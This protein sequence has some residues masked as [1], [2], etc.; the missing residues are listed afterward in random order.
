MKQAQTIRQPN[1][2]CRWRIWRAYRLGA[3]KLATQEV[4]EHV[5]DGEFLWIARDTHEGTA[6]M[7]T[8]C[9]VRLMEVIDHVPP[10][11]AEWV[12]DQT[13]AALG[14]LL[15]EMAGLEVGTG[16]ELT[17]RPI[18]PDGQHEHFARVVGLLREFLQFAHAGA[19]VADK[20]DGLRELVEGARGDGAG[21]GRAAA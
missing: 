21:A 10:A 6:W 20:L 7:I 19:V 18:E 8:D 1:T 17:A 4:A 15:A 16:G 3:S 9:P 5:C 11:M 12:I 14:G 2:T 13:V